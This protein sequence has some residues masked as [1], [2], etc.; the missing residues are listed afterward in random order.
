MEMQQQRTRGVVDLGGELRR[1]QLAMESELRELNWKWE[2]QRQRAVD[3]C[4]RHR[5]VV[6]QYLAPGPRGGLSSLW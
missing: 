6:N 5:I 4:E 3:E 1:K 2:D